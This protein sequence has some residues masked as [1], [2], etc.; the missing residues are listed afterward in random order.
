MTRI[1][2]FLFTLTLASIAAM[3]FIEN[4]GSITLEWLGYRV[5]TSVAFAVLASIVVIIICTTLL[6]MLLWI[7]GAP[8][9]YRKAMSERKREQGL[10]ALTNGFAA[11]AAGD[12]R[13]AKKLTKQ[14]TN[15]LGNISLTKLL[16]AQTAQLEGN[17]EL[18]KVHYTSMLENKDTEIIAIKGLLIQ[19]RQDGDFSKAVFLAE[20]AIALRPDADWAV[21]ILIEM[22]KI[23]K[24]WTEVEQVLQRALKL[25]IIGK[26]EYQR[27]MSLVYMARSK[28]MAAHGDNREAVKL[29][30]KSYKL[31]PDF[32]PVITGYADILL[33]DGNK[34]KAAKILEAGWKHAPHSDIAESYMAV[35]GDE[36]AAKKLNKAERLL[37]LQPSNPHGHLIVA[38]TAML[39]D[40]YGKA[41]NHLKIALGSIETRSICALMAEVEKQEGS[42]P[43]VIQQW[44]QRLETSADDHSW[45]CEKCNNS[46]A[47]WSVNCNNCDAF[48]SLVWGNASQKMR[49]IQPLELLK[50]G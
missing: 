34:R 19:A 9:K 18:A 16:A 3:W 39:A 21:L 5:Q 35:Y 32:V 30:A 1:F 13:Q 10:T 33:Q 23:T 40:E 6:Q 44:K 38:K 29:A 17:R 45:T 28:A 12:I 46:H 20:K 4:D 15:C 8:R 26:D 36:N 2:I 43:D 24:R 27:S 25:K 48:D 22:Y 47:K 14:A 11:I 42:S 50:A 37:A 49:V 41:R 7:K 31:L